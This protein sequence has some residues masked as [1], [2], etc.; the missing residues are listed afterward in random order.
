VGYLLQEILIKSAKQ[1]ANNIAVICGDQYVTYKKLDEVSDKLAILL[2]ENGVKRG[3]R[4]GIYINKS[5]PSIIGIYGILKAGAVYV[6]LDP[7]APPSRLAYIIKDCGIKCLLTSTKMIERLIQESDVQKFLGLI[8][9]TDSLEH[10]SKIFSVKIIPWENIVDREQP[11][12]FENPSIETDL[13]YILYT[14]GS[15][16]VPKGVMISHLNSLTFINWAFEAIN[17]SPQDNVSSH[18]PLHFDLSIF[19]IFVTFKGGATL[20]LVPEELSSFPFRLVDWIIN[21][22]ISVWYSVPS[23]L[24]KLVLN[25][26]LER[27][28]FPDLKSVIFAGEVFPPKYLRRLMTSIPHAHYYNFYGPTRLQNCSLTPG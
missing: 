19:D 27:Y 2:Q 21:R 15:T 4:V 17:V 5:I 1:Y 14:S 25:G 7:S 10:P 11:S 24:S 6:P 8:V 28:T 20:V 16:G 13:A 12:P 26:E 3:D 22:Q 23:V 18:A 9:L